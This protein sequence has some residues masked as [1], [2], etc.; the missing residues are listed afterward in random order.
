MSPRPTADRAAWQTLADRLVAGGDGVEHGKMVSSDA[1]T[2]RQGLRLSEQ[3]LETL[4]E[5]ARDVITFFN[6]RVLQ[7]PDPFTES[8]KG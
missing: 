5:H 8:D 3:N 6:Y 7:D 1:V 4:D 2:R